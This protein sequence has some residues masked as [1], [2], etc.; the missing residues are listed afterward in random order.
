MTGVHI[1]LILLYTDETFTIFCHILDNGIIFNGNNIFWNHC[2]DKT[3]YKK[4]IVINIYDLKYIY[5]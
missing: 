5:L 1:I 2:V 4:I 3:I